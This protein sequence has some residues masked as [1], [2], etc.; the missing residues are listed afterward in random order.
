MPNSDHI[1]AFA[2]RESMRSFLS[3][4]VASQTGLFLLSD[5]IRAARAQGLGPAAQ[6]GGSKGKRLRMDP[7]GS[8]LSQILES[9]GLAF[10]E[11]DNVFMPV[12][13]FFKEGGT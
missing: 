3:D 1:S 4:Y 11:P 9:E 8:V 5:L 7:L 2:S 13:A 6:A 12:A 10:P